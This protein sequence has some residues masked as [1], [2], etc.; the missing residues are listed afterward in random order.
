MFKAVI[1]EFIDV[2]QSDAVFCAACGWHMLW[3]GRRKGE[4]AAEAR[5]THAVFA[6]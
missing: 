6:G 2:L 4:D 5:V 3:V 1:E